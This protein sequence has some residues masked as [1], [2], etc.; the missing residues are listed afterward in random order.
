MLFDFE[1]LPGPDRYKLLTS[2]IVPRPIAWVVT[3]DA[4]GRA[5]VAPYSFFNAFAAD[6]P[7]V[8]VG[9]G[10]RPEGTPKDS[11]ANLTASGE[12]TVCLVPAAALDAMTVTAADFE[13][14]FSELDAAGLTAVPSAKVAPPR[15][16]ESPVALE[17]VVHQ[18]VA[19]SPSNALV[20]GRVVAMDV[21]DD[22]VLDA[23]RRHVDTPRLDLVGRMHGGGGY[24]RTTDR[25]TVPRISAADWHARRG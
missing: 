21:R 25:V 9:M 10:S 13:A 11:L 23:V 1:A 4:E 7:V 2:T 22:C 24:V 6:P 19:L 3:L 18:I 15:L 8:A 14:G 12:F 17:C 16:A 5:N 20:L